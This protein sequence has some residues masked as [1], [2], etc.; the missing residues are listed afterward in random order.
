MALKNNRAAGLSRRGLL[1]SSA[2]M[3]GCGRRRG[4]A[5][6]GYAFV[7]NADGRSLAIVDLSIFSVARRI[8][9]DA[10]PSAVIAH[11]D[12]AV[13]YALTP[14]NGTVVEVDGGTLAVRRKLRLGASAVGMHLAADALSLWVLMAEPRQ[15]VRVPLD[16]FTANERIRLPGAPWDFD[17]SADAA[18]VSFPEQGAIGVMPLTG[19]GPD[20]LISTGGDPRLLEI[21]RAGASRSATR[22]PAKLSCAC[23]CRSSRRIFASKPTA[24]SFLSRGREWTA[25]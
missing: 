10:S 5:F 12:H 4:T 20:R 2:A 18:A 19:R 16:R 1:L 15:L 7:A 11:P 23:R 24:A 17:L 6:P 3:L 22:R 14:A 9:L 21:A 25:W 13:I 8:P